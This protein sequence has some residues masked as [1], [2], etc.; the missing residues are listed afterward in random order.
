MICNLP[1]HRLLHGH[2]KISTPMMGGSRIHKRQNE[3]GA[4]YWCVSDFCGMDAAVPSADTDL[5]ELEWNGNEFMLDMSDSIP[6]LLN[7]GLLLLIRWKEQMEREFPET[8]FDIVLSVDEGEDGVPPSVTLRFY[9]VRD[10]VHYVEPTQESM[11]GF[12]QP[13]LL[14][15]VNQ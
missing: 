2:P 8:P 4:P 1:M 3:A 15:T 6:D 10:G 11:D 13:I 9:A 7:A 14:E 12:A 5:T